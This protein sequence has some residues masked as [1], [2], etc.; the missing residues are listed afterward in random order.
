M[1]EGGK[2]SELID[3]RQFLTDWVSVVDPCTI[4]RTDHGSFRD[5]ALKTTNISADML[6][7]LDSVCSLQS[8]CGEDEPTSVEDILSNIPAE[9]NLESVAAQEKDLERR[10]LNSSYES[11][12]LTRLK[13]RDNS[14][15][16][17]HNHYDVNH[18]ESGGGS[19]FTGPEVII[20]IHVY[21]RNKRKLLHAI[22]VLASQKLTALKDV[23][24]CIADEMIV[25]EYSDIP[26]ADHTIKAKEMFKSSY[27]FIENVFYNDMRDPLCKDYSKVIINWAKDPN[28]QLPSYSAKKMEETTFYDLSVRIGEPYVYVHQG[29]CEHV[30]SFSD[31]RILHR[32]E[33]HDVLQY[34]IIIEDP[35][36]ITHSIMCRVCSAH[37]ASWLT[38]DSPLTPE[39]PCFFCETCFRMLHYDSEGQRT[40]GKFRAYKYP[41]MRPIIKRIM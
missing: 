2:R 22:D 3:I 25:G 19:G 4:T 1:A 37:C 35:R 39:N 11:R 14:G 7:E 34:P 29:D 21:R 10:K 31:I 5:Y 32:N 30:I 28:R 20:T 16:W 9:T 12:V 24:T 18:F 33:C 13:Y 8:L 41:Q 17:L 27:F 38:Y 40:V 23:I 36:N 6:E 15:P 26:E